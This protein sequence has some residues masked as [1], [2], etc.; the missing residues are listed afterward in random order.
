VGKKLVL[1]ESEGVLYRGPTATHPTEVWVYPR[2]GWVP[3]GYAGQKEKGWG[4]RITARHAA[5]LKKNN[6]AAE[7]FNYYDTPP[8]SQ[9]ASDAYIAA[10]IPDHVKRRVAKL[11]RSGGEGK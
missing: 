5:R 6:A 8:W 4:K 2:G 3:Y 10:V 7:H 11:Q 1:I 9:P